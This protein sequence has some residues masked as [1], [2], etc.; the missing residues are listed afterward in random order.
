[1]VKDKFEA[2]HGLVGGI[3]NKVWLTAF[4]IQFILQVKKENMFG[5]NKSF[6]FLL[7]I[8]IIMFVCGFFN[9]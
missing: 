5:C 3:G 8:L 4:T 7:D 6:I 9:I 2:F 1:M